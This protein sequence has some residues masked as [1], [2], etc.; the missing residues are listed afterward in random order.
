MNWLSYNEHI[1][2]KYYT[3]LL[4]FFKMGFSILAASIRDLTDSSQ[5]LP[6]TREVANLLV[7]PTD[8][9]RS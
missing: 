1:S 6:A 4:N 5:S 3:Y 2:K 7:D 8:I 9:I